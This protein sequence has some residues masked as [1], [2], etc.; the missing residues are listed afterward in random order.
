M[1]YHSEYPTT[2]RTGKFY[3]NCE[4]FNLSIKILRHVRFEVPTKVTGAY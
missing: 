1:G 2:A 4:I 3:R